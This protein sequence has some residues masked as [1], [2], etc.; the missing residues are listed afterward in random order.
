LHDILSDYNSGMARYALHLKYEL[1]RDVIASILA[2]EK[3]KND[4]KLHFAAFEGSP[5][6]SLEDA[7][8]D[9]LDEVG[10]ISI[11]HMTQSYIATGKHQDETC[12]AVTLFYRHGSAT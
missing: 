8:N 1:P 3:P 2:K 10:P 12:L 6:F 7:L 9:F 11:V 4:G 5:Y